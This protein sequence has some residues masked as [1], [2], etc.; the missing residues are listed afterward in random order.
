MLCVDFTSCNKSNDELSSNNAA[1]LGTWAEDFYVKNGK[2][3]T[4]TFILYKQ[5]K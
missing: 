1:I 4:D 5:S 2:T 3:Q